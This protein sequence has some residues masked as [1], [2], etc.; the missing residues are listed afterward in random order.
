MNIFKRTCSLVFIT[1]TLIFYRSPPPDSCM[2]L[3]L[4]FIHPNEPKA[5][6][7]DTCTVMVSYSTAKKHFKSPQV[8][9]KEEAA[10]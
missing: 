5:K 4:V 6:K 8:K 2:L 10:C 9:D 1:L 7:F 3:K